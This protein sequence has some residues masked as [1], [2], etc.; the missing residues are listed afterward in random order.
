MSH[1]CT[2]LL[3][4]PLPVDPGTTSSNRRLWL[5]GSRNARPMK[6]HEAKSTGLEPA[7]LG[8][9][10]STAPWSPCDLRCTTFLCQ[11]GIITHTAGLSRKRDGP[12]KLPWQ[13]PCTKWA[14]Q[15]DSPL[16]LAFLQLTRS[17]RTR[18]LGMQET[19]KIFLRSGQGYE[20]FKQESMVVKFRL[21]GWDGE[22]RDYKPWSPERV[23]SVPTGWAACLRPSPH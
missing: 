2:T 11:M 16:L 9:K 1:H 19:G 4:D 20:A 3:P 10:P 13:V 23:V 6:S 12:W 8:S 7:R 22:F 18:S 17:D 21:V 14:P 15:C 5:L